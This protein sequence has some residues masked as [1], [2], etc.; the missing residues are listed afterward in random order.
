MTSDGGNGGGGGFS[1]RW[2]PENAASG[3]NGFGEAKERRFS[4][5]RSP[6]KFAG[7][8]GRGH[9]RRGSKRDLWR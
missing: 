9:E 3:A 4:F 5:F 8:E 2:S 1:P 7:A 6:P